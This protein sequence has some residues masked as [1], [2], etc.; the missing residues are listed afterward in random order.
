M[1]EIRRETPSDLPG[2]RLV[3]ER[4]FG[5][6]AEANLVDSLRAANKAVISL[7]ALH[8]DRVVGHILFSPISV[9]RAPATLRGVGLA[10]MGVLPELQQTGI[11]SRLVRDGLAECQ[12]AGYDIVVV[13]GHVRYYRR[14]GFSPARAYGLENEYQAGD[15]FMVLE[16]KKGVLET[17]AGLVRFAPEFHE[18]GC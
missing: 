9:E 15:A 11:G 16:L 12:R 2:I 10:P 6:S 1:I 7:V 3:N 17:V 14:F 4:A 18:A 5:S 8:D 13:L